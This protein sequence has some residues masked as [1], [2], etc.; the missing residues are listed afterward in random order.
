MSDKILSPG[1]K[2]YSSITV[3]NIFQLFF[4]P[5]RYTVQFTPP[6]TMRVHASPT[7]VYPKY[8][9][10][11]LLQRYRVAYCI[12]VAHLANS[13]RVRSSGGK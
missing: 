6:Q 9:V 8:G 2:C 10:I 5:E 12:N 3:D 1:D 11:I 13:S 4:I 7:R